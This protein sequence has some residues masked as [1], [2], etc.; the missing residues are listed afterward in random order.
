METQRSTTQLSTTANA[1]RPWGSSWS[2]HNNAR[3]QF[4]VLDMSMWKFGRVIGRRK[5]RKTANCSHLG[6]ECDTIGACAPGMQVGGHIVE[7][8]LRYRLRQ[9][10]AN[11]EGGPGLL[12]VP[13]KPIAAYRAQLGIVALG[14]GQK[15]GL[16]CCKI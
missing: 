6:G 13:V 12:F 11:V 9:E 3:T 5:K 16:V 10:K 7:V 14:I 15:M 1:K 4:V 2:G 8:G